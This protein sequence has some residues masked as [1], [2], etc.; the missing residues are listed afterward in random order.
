M[1]EPEEVPD[2]VKQAALVLH[3]WMKTRSDWY[4][5]FTLLGDLI[6]GRDMR[7]LIMRRPHHDIWEMHYES[8]SPRDVNVSDAVKKMYKQWEP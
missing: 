2:E 1:I 3:D 8:R 7:P 4:P 5:L 6:Q